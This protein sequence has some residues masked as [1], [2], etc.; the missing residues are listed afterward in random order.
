M[1][2]ATVGKTI[3]ALK[4]SPLTLVLLA[5]NLCFLVFVAY[6]LGEVASNASER[7]KAQLEMI[8][9]LVKELGNCRG[10]AR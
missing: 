7:N 9:T 4:G 1:V 2:K 6:V 5:V 3:D 10:A 8:G